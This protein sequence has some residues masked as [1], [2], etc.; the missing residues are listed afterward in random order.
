MNVNELINTIKDVAISQR[1]AS[2]YDGDVYA[3]WNSAEAKY[4]SV[5]VGLQNISYD[6]NLCTYTVVLY[7]G[8]RLLQD[9]SNV[10]SIYS[11]GLRVLQGIINALNELDGVNIEFP[12]LYTPFE[13]QFMDYLAGVYATVDIT[14]ASELGT[15][16]INDFGEDINNLNPQNP[17]IPDK[18]INPP[19]GGNNPIIIH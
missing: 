2:A 5:N 17:Y 18:P 1:V 8:D 9:K 19:G 3:S 4:G 6:S 16:D 13:Q 14:C 12:V 11:D 15:C 7:Y 10:N